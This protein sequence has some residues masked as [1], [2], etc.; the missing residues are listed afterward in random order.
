M[1]PLKQTLKKVNLLQGDVFLRSNNKKSADEPERYILI[2][3]DK[4]LSFKA[5]KGRKQELFPEIRGKYNE[6]LLI[7]TK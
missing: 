7:N 5:L 6:K 1:F 2:Y 3:L 4:D